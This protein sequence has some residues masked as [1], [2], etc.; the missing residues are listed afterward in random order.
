MSEPETKM[1]LHVGLT[2]G[3]LDR[4]VAFYRDV[5]GMTLKS[6]FAAKNEWFDDLTNNP[7]SELSVAHLRLGKYEL[8]L[9]EYIAGGTADPAELAHNRIG[10]PH[11]CFLV[12]DVEAKFAEVVARGDVTITSKVID[13]VAGARS[14]YTEDPDGVPVEFV[15]PGRR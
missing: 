7:G 13:I 6:E 2:V 8:Q 11:M 10:S 15:Q 4:S 9:I 12:T 14:F 1:L 3:D 5:V